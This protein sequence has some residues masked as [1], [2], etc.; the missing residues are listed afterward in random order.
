MAIPAAIAGGGL[1]GIGS[2]VGG[3]FGSSAAKKQIQ[4]IREMIAEN[5]R[6]YDDTVARMAPYYDFGKERLNAFSNWL[7]D[8]TKDPMSQLDPG[9]EFRRQEGMKSLTGNAATA[10][11]LQSGDTLRAIQQYG[12]DLSSSEYSN[13]FDR[14][15]AQHQAKM[16]EAGVGQDAAANL[17]QLGNQMS[18]INSNLVAGTDWGAPQRIW[19][20]VAGGVGGMAGNALARYLQMPTPRT[21]V[22]GGSNIF[23]DDRWDMG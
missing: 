2:V 6:Q 13:A 23:G 9:Y 18:N 19:G 10:G 20:D 17:G 4:A 1:A 21:R 11:M 14:W 16:R 8:P 5:R 3:L 15:L 22:P 12:Q 7:E